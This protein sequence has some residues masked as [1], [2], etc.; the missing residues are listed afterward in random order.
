MRPCS[1]TRGY[2]GCDKP[3]DGHTYHHCPECAAHPNGGWAFATWI[4]NPL[5]RP[6]DRKRESMHEYADPWAERPGGA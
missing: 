2:C 5:K 3:A 4:D 6:Q 1:A